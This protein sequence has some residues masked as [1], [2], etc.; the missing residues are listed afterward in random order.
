LLYVACCVYTVVG[1]NQI[2]KVGNEFKP[3]WSRSFKLN[4]QFGLFLLLLI[5]IPRFILVLKANETGNYSLLG[6]VMLIS[7]SV[8]FLLLS[9][10]GKNQIGIKNTSK[11]YNLILALFIGL[12]LSIILHYLGVGLYGNSYQNWFGYIGKSYSIPE[13]ISCED[14]KTLFIIMAATGMVFSPVGEELFF[15]GIVHSSFAKS[16]GDMKASIIDSLAFALIHISHFGLVFIDQSWKFYLV[17]A[18]IWVISMFIVSIIFFQMKKHT[19]SIWG[20]VVCHSGFNLG[21][22]YCI[23]YL[24]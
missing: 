1:G 2:K 18:L 8:P 3:L 16:I 12:L 23:F 22:I 21:M 24:I 14:K 4:W 9:K 20:A 7:A 11:V 17:P 6:L 13:G 15:R 10:Y 19:D 5:C